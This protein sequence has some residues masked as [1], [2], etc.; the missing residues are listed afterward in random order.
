MA[1]CEVQEVGTGP[2]PGVGPQPGAEDQ[3]GRVGELAGTTVK[4]RAKEGG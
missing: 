3:A 2:S 1:Y 4:V